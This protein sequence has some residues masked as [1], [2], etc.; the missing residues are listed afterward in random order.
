MQNDTK[1]IIGIVLLTVGLLG[2][3]IY[4]GNR[5]TASNGGESSE[6]GFST[7]K[8]DIGELVNEGDNSSGNSDAKVT[9]VEFSD[10][11]CPYCKIAHPEI[12]AL[13]DLFS[14]EELRIVF[15]HLPLTEIHNQAYPAAIAAQAATR[16]GKF[17]QYA[18]ALYQNSTKLNEAFYLQL[19][20]DLGLNIEQFKADR[21]LEE[22][23][24]QAYRA[25]DYI[26]KIGFQQVTP[27]IFINSVEY[28]GE[29]TTAAFA[30]A[31]SQQL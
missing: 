3:L 2:V 16:Q 25:R 8:L 7:E 18:D 4:A 6:L 13:R 21:E 5:P 28:Q 1:V 26:D 19:A 20:S 14:D 31:I 12:Q 11:E 17:A 23:R 15:R 30:D 9:L 27:T 24:W 22:V 10:F 29:R